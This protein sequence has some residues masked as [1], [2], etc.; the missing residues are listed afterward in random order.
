MDLLNGYLLNKKTVTNNYSTLPPCKYQMFL[1]I[2]MYVYTVFSTIDNILRLLRAINTIRT[3]SIQNLNN[4][5]DYDISSLCSRQY[6]NAVACRHCEGSDTRGCYT[7]CRLV[8]L[9]CL[10]PLSDALSKPYASFIE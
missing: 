1:Q 3:V 7:S 9:F 6:I 10:Q 4:A 5:L 2:S 8:S